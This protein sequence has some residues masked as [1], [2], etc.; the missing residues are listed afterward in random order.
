MIE[1]VSAGRITKINEHFI[2][3]SKEDKSIEVTKLV[4]S[5]DSEG[6]TPLFYAW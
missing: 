3:M 1:Q 5:M 2:S 4:N 6:K